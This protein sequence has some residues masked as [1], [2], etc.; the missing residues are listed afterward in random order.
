VIDG[1]EMNP[2]PQVK[3]ARPD[4]GLRLNQ[5]KE[6]EELKQMLETHQQEMS[7]IKKGTDALGYKFDPLSEL[8]TETIKDQSRIK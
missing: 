2:G 1:V 3:Q 5:E 8:V 4:I 7:E 6:D